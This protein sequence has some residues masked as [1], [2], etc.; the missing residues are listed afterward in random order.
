M[1][2]IP[3]CCNS[4]PVPIISLKAGGLSLGFRCRTY[5]IVAVC[6]LLA[7]LIAIG[8]VR[9]TSSKSTELKPP[10][11]EV[12]L[13]PSPSVLRK[14]TKGAVCSDGAPCSEIGR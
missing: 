4:T 5:G 3:R 14:F 13:P 7:I 2:R 11:T 10:D 6:I 8:I 9:L 12:P 1:D